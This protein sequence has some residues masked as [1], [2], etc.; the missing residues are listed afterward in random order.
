MAFAQALL[1]VG[2]DP[3]GCGTCDAC[4]RV[5]ARTPEPPHLPLHPDVVLVARGLYRPETLGKKEQESTEIS[6][7]Q[8][9]RVVLGRVAFPPHEGRAQLFVVRDAEQLS[10]GAANAL[11]K[12]LEEPRPDTYFLLLTAQPERLLSTIR[13]RSLP[14]RFGPLP[15]P[16]VQGILRAQGHD[17]PAAE[18][19]VALGQG[20][21]SAAL[22]AVDPERS[23]ARSEFV[24]G[25]LEA[26]AHADPA[27]AVVLGERY[28]G[29][30]Q[31]LASDLRALGTRLAQTSRALLGRSEARAEAF[32][33]A[34]ELVSRAL[35]AVEH[36]ASR[37]LTLSSLVLGLRDLG[38]R[39][40]L[41]SDG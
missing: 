14:V 12:T 25:V 40:D 33:R 27:A 28:N 15:D 13:S 38:I 17:G 6:V 37:Q 1:C 3:L 30:R 39:D 9:R 21:A 26:A 20:S 29:D 4:R 22:D 10:T 11:L 41:G 8:V 24:V 36:N 23:A 16:V 32:A 7:A 35:D 34:H 18:A 2:G 19:A 31:Q 5:V